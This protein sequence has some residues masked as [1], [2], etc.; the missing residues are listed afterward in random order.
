MSDISTSRRS[1]L[2]GFWPP[3][4]VDEALDTAVVLGTCDRA[5]KKSQQSERKVKARD[6]AEG[7]LQIQA[8]TGNE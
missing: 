5:T 6:E 7:S 4:S 8:G 1:A 3:L 2:G